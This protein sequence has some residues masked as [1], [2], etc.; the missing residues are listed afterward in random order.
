MVS[1]HLCHQHVSCNENDCHTFSAS[2]VHFRGFEVGLLESIVLS[3]TVT[4]RELLLTSWCLPTKESIY[5][6]MITAFRL[7]GYEDED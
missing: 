1:M 6:G 4:Q 7:E 3:L 2:V 5:S